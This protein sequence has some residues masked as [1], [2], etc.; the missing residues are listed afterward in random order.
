M[1]VTLAYWLFILLTALGKIVAFVAL[2]VFA[3]AL[4]LSRIQVARRDRVANFS[5]VLMV[6]LAIAAFGVMG[7]FLLL[8]NVRIFLAAA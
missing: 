8:E 5:Q 7:V 6:D 2:V 4:P 3:I 1:L